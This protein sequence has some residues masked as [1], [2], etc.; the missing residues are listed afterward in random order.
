VPGEGV[1]RREV[2]F[3]RD[4]R[5]QPFERGGDPLGTGRYAGWRRGG[6]PFRGLAGASGHRALPCLRRTL[7]GAGKS[8][9]AQ[10]FALASQAGPLLAATLQLGARPL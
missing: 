1:G 9:Q 2:R 10:G 4:R 3:R 7:S 5:R 6:W 8:L